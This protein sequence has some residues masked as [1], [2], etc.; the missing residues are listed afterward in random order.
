MVLTM[1]DLG[2]EP[3][4]SCKKEEGESSR[5]RLHPPGG[6]SQLVFRL[7]TVP[8]LAWLFI[9]VRG[10]G[11][12]RLQ[13]IML[14]FDYTMLNMLMPEEGTRLGVQWEVE[15]KGDPGLSKLFQSI[16]SE[17]VNI[18]R[19]ISPPRRFIQFFS[20]DHRVGVE[21]SFQTSD[22]GLTWRILTYAHFQWTETYRL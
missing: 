13:L 19:R 21:G 9:K 11:S 10:P 7:L 12:P 6:Q 4:S 1:Y 20:T 16:Q 15:G 17:R 22:E 8:C 2:L 14:F 18:S 5:R 3:K